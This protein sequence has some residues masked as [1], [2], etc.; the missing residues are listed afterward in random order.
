GDKR[1]VG[2]VTGVADS[3]EIRAALG[4]RLPAYMVPAAVVVLET[5]PLTVNGKLDKR[6]LPAPEYEDAGGDYRAP[7]SAV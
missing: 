4:E 3:A 5:L 6:A 1:L 7:A 2:Y